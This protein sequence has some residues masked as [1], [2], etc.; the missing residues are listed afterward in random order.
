MLSVVAMF[1]KMKALR[2]INPIGPTLKSSL[3]LIALI[4][5]YHYICIF[6]R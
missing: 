5:T 4:L 1:T 2:S 3:V 6:V